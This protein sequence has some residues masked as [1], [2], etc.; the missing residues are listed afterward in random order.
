[1]PGQVIFDGKE[2][3]IK[4]RKRA[5]TPILLGVKHLQNGIKIPWL[6]NRLLRI[7]WTA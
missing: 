4:I 6:D 3:L 2:F 1:M 7:E 5:H